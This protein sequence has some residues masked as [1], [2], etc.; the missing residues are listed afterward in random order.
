[1]SRRRRGKGFSEP[2]VEY[3]VSVSEENPPPA[4]VLERVILSGGGG[5]GN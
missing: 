2:S 5:G 3:P 1:M 4:R